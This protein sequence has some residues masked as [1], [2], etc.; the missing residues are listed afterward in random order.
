MYIVYRCTTV[1]VVCKFSMFFFWFWRPISVILFYFLVLRIWVCMYVSAFG[2]CWLLSAKALWEHCLEIK[3]KWSDYN[4]NCLIL[5]FYVCIFCVCIFL[6]RAVYTYRGTL[7]CKLRDIIGKVS[8]RSFRCGPP[9]A[10]HRDRW[11]PW[12]DLETRFCRF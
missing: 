4:N 7:L 10:K 12:W 9:C 1:C 5:Y 6:Y 11:S 8:K 3:T 2:D